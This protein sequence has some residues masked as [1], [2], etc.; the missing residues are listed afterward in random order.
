MA[1]IIS[2]LENRDGDILYPIAGGA[3]DGSIT[4]AMIMDN[5]ISTAK[6][7]NNAVTTAKI[8]DL[9]V[10]TADLADGAAT[11]AKRKPTVSTLTSTIV[12]VSDS[13]SVN[14]TWEQ[15]EL[16]GDEY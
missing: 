9:G 14:I 2:T 3:A 7:A 8:P 13:Q 11:G 5:A 4:T 12:R 6:I 16:G 1:D 10:A 15:I